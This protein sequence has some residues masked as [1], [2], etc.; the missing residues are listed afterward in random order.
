M[1]LSKFG[2]FLPCLWIFVFTFCFYLVAYICAVYVP[3]VV[4]LLDKKERKVLAWFVLVGTAVAIYFIAIL[5]NGP[6]DVHKVNSCVTYNFNFPLQNYVVIAYLVA[7][8]GS[9][10]ISSINILR[11]FGIVA[12]FLGLIAWLFFALAFT[13]VWCFFAGVV[14]LMFY[15]YIRYKRKVNKLLEVVDQKVKTVGRK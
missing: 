12:G 11:Y 1:A 13:S 6:L 7:I 8:I 10:S 14:S 3:F 4:F 5:M 15:F 9:L 2:I